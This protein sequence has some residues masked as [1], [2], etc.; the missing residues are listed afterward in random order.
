MVEWAALIEQCIVKRQSR[1][2]K[3][4]GQLSRMRQALEPLAG[5]SPDEAKS[6]PDKNQFHA[7]PPPGTLQV[8]ARQCKRNARTAL[9]LQ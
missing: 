5:K 9:W 1:A 8:N 4:D 6:Q 7:Q 3:P 2:L